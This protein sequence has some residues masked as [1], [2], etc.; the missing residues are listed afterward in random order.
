MTKS[1]E[2]QRQADAAV[3]G[4]INRRL[5]AAGLERLPMFKKATKVV[6]AWCKR[7]ITDGVEPVSHGIC[8]GCLAGQLEKL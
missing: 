1:H 7:V 4:E 8:P 2:E 6:C 3:H 5:D